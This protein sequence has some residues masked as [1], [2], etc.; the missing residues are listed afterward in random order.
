MVYRPLQRFYNPT[1]WPL[2]RFVHVADNENGRGIG[3]GIAIIQALPGAVSGGEN[4]DINLVAM[5]NATK[6]TVLGFLGIP[7]N[8]ASGHER[9]KYVF[10]YSLLF[11]GAGDWKENGIH[12]RIPHPLNSPVVTADSPDVYTA[13]VKPANR[14]EGVIVR[15]SALCPPESPVTLESAVLNFTRAFLCDTRERDIE[16]L[17][18]NN[19]RVKFEMAGTSATLRLLE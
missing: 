16:A 6:E 1:F 9:E 15:L 2:H 10:E 4:G 19:G 14:G 3:R 11:T 18:V 17:K 7:G 8:P 13:A 12:R 5:R